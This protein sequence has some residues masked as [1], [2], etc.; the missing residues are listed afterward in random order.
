MYLPGLYKKFFLLCTQVNPLW[1]AF[2]AAC[3][4]LQKGNTFKFAGG[5]AQEA[6][7]V[8]KTLNNSMY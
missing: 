7:Y 1:K 3:C 6:K 8:T 2:M 5:A 4:S